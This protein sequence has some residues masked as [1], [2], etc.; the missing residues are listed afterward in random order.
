MKPW[1]PAPARRALGWAGGALG[2]VGYAVL[3]HRA[4]SEA[5]PG[6][7]EAAVFIVPLMAFALALAWRS[8]RRGVWTALWLAATV[9]LVALRGRLGAGTQWVL[10]AQ[11]V[12][13]NALLCLVFARTLAAG[14]TPLV[15]QLATIVHSTLSP[16]VAR[17]TR[18]VTWAWAGYFGITAIASALLFALAPAP[19]WSA[20]VNLLSLPLLAA[21]FIGEYLVRI[22]MV[23]REERSSIFQAVAAWREFSSRK[24]AK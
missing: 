7:F 5:H 11:H 12:G 15:T 4:A 17:Y 19:V 1:P 16:G 24:S 14:S 13:I 10:L 22:V 18:G 8:P 6:L 21:M 2:I 3:A 9:V 23:P 20:F